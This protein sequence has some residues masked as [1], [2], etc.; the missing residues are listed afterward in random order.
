MNP[1][2]LNLVIA[3]IWFFMVGKHRALDFALGFVIGFLILYAFQGMLNRP[4]YF[5]RALAGLRYLGMYLKKMFLSNLQ[6]AYA[7]LHPK[8]PVKPGIFDIPVDGL[9]PVEILVLANTISL[10]P[11]TISVDVDEKG[12]QLV[13]HG[14]VIP[15]LERVSAEIYQEIL[16]L[17]LKVT[18]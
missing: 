9:T 4:P 1:F 3:L 12:T 5:R 14:L 16:G 15:E 13:V 2:S 11:G 17:L 7:I 8:M 18:R 10:I 6:M